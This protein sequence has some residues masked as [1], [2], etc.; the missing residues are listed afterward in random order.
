MELLLKTS[1]PGL[2]ERGDIVKVKPGYARNYLLPKKMAVPAT[3]SMKRVILQENR[4]IEIRE[5]KVKR[6]L[7]EVAKKMKDLSCT[8][9]V[10]AGEED[11]LYGSVTAHDIAEAI[12]QQG[13]DVDQKMVMLEDPIKMLGVYTVD[14]RI[15]REIELPVKIWVVKE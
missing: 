10:Q 12:S 7:Q 5:D 11:K 3:E 15:H 14:I 8:I 2:G 9:V 13:F 4:L 6:S 1:V